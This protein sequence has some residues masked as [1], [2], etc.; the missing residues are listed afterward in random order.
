MSAGDAL[1]MHGDAE[2][3]CT[4]H[5]SLVL[6]MLCEPLKEYEHDGQHVSTVAKAMK[7]LMPM[8]SI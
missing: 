6:C 3:R 4:D 5:H 2:V 7:L 8:R 1:P